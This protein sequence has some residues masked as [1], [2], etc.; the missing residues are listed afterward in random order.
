[1]LNLNG[2]TFQF[3]GGNCHCDGNSV[4]EHGRNHPGAGSASTIEVY[5]G[6]SAC[7]VTLTAA[8]LTRG[9]NASGAIHGQR[10]R[11]GHG[12]RQ[13]DFIALPAGVGTGAN[14]VLSY[15]TIDS[16]ANPTQ[17]L[18]LGGNETIQRFTNYYTRPTAPSL[19]SGAVYLLDETTDGP[20]HANA[21]QSVNSNVSLTAMLVRGNGTL[22]RP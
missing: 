5:V 9:N 17:D 14:A 8:N 10:R 2:G 13:S 22:P 7:A 20:G 11:A 21:V 15:A 4:P 12:R 3:V 16:A 19:G 18:V 6:C 1:M